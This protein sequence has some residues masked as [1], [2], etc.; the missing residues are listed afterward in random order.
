MLL[1]DSLFVILWSPRETSVTTRV[2]P[3]NDETRS[4]LYVYSLGARSFVPS[5]EWWIRSVSQPVPLVAYRVTVPPLTDQVS[6]VRGFVRGTP[7]REE[8]GTLG[9]TNPHIR[10]L[11]VEWE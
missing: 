2:T 11:S 3:D 8:G 1:P 6:G 5:E 4:V 9:R 7:H 10:R